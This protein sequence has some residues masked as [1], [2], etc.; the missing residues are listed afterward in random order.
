MR[1]FA[2]VLGAASLH[3][4]LLTFGS[5]SAL[6][7]TEGAPTSGVL[8]TFS[9][10][11]PADTP[12]N[13]TGT[14]NWGDGTT[15]AAS[16]TGS[17]GSF[18]LSGAHTY[19]EE[20]TYSMLLNIAD[21]A[22]DTGSAGGLT[23]VVSDAPLSGS[24]AAGFG[25][26]PGVAVSRHSVDDLHRCKSERAGLGFCRQHLMGRWDTLVLRGDYVGRRECLR[27]ERIAH[28]R[29]WRD[30]YGQRKYKRHWGIEHVGADYR[31]GDRDAGAGYDWDG[32]CWI[33]APRAEADAQ[34]LTIPSGP[35][36]ATM[37]MKTPG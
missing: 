16:F 3:A 1:F 25:F 34:E 37:E 6:P 4:G 32:V 31:R 22:G 2:L 27:R 5:F 14:I 9:D 33:R 15:S 29:G 18:S 17:N 36:S 21:S 20:G 13:F 26:T 23:E 11:N 8:I 19:V 7:A 30:I 12:G 28:I 24:S 10:S 35:T